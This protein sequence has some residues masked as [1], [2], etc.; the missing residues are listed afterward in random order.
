M[1]IT[2]S[3][4]FGA[5]G[6]MVARKVAEQLQWRLIDNEV[7]AEVARRTGMSL[8]DVAARD[9][10]GS[11]FPE[12]LARVLMASSA[13]AMAPGALEA[14]EAEDA[15]LVRVVEQVVADECAGG[16]A[17]VLGRA[18]VAV[19]GRRSDALHVKVV[20]SPGWRTAHLVSRLEIGTDEAAKRVKDVDAHR[21][22]YHRQWYDRDWA[23]PRNYHLVVNTEWLGVDCAAAIVVDAL[24]RFKG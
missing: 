19:I 7:V 13:E 20:A 6:S 14:T 18:A 17:V 8:E 4:E 16:D 23:D 3:R 22:R 1:L 9:E 15:K 10:R 21:G 5:G 11:T 24:Q 12:R 2:I